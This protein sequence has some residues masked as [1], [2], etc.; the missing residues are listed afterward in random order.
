MSSPPTDDPTPIWDR[1]YAGSLARAPLPPPDYQPDSIV[2]ELFRDPG[3]F[4]F[5]QAVW[6][7]ERFQLRHRQVGRAAL[8]TQEPIRFRTALGAAFPPSAIVEAL[9]PS[10]DCP[11]VEMTVALLGLTGPSGILPR[12]YTQLIYDLHRFAKSGEKDALR[13]WFDL[14][15]SRLLALYY[16]GWEKYRLHRA[17]DVQRRRG[18]ETD[19]FTQ[20]VFSLCGLG[21]PQL[22]DRLSVTAPPEDALSQKP[23]RLA[24]IN[25]LG[26]LRYAGLLSQR[27]RTPSN[28]RQLLRDYFSLP[29]EVRQF[30]GQWLAL[31]PSQQTSLTHSDG[32]NALGMSAVAGER[33]W[34][35]QSKIRIQLGPL[36]G[37]QFLEFLPD[38]RPTPERKSFYVLCH[39][40]RLFIGPEFDFDIQ[41]ELQ[42][43]EAPRCILSGDPEHGS[44]LG[45]T[46]WLPAENRSEVFDDAFFDSSARQL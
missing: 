13:D 29:V 32:N 39:L 3:A 2:G 36:T 19:N 38:D 26:L 6:L 37:E 30:Q 4:D 31:E 10:L 34:N 45:W 1:A 18:P 41:L 22:R 27:P 8:P 14:F 23:I 40:T 33:V 24:E 15:N 44:R 5:F 42:A 17:L 28:L 16:R 25:D 11:Q 35:V 43:D 7:L 46:T 21:F 12:H 20:S 9:P